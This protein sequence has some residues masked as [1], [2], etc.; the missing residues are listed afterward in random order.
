M[1]RDD[2]T[3][4]VADP[5]EA[6]AVYG[7]GYFGV[8]QSGGLVLDRFE[9]VYLLEM[10]RLPL[11]D[12]DGHPVLWPELFRRATRAEE[13]FGVRYIVYRDLRQRGYVVRSSPPPDAFSVLPRGGILH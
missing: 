5:S 8:I 3:A 4:L 10:D 11:V 2:A 6:G 12:S 1:V 7:R 9:S 13:G